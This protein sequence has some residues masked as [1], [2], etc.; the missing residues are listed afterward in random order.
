MPL[1]EA[2]IEFR[3]NVSKVDGYIGLAFEKDSSSQNVRNTEEIEF[4]VSSAFL[5]LFI[6][7]EAFLE[8]SFISYLTANPSLDG[9]K[10]TVSA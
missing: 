10:L 4:L 1:S 8:K 2:L 3:N 9:D 6:A 7:W 5:K